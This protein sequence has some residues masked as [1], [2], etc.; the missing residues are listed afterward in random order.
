MKRKEIDMESIVIDTRNIERIKGSEYYSFENKIW[1]AWDKNGNRI[2]KFS[3]GNGNT[4]RSMYDK[5][6]GTEI[7]RD[8]FGYM[9]NKDDLEP[10][11]N[12][13]NATYYRKK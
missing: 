2:C 8:G 1:W 6:A 13:D 11:F 7:Y 4:S 12:A 10:V 5:A 9:G 3:F